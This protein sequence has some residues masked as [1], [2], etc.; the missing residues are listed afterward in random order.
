MQLM[1]TLVLKRGYQLACRVTSHLPPA[2]LAWALAK[3]LNKNLTAEIADG[4]FDFLNEKILQIA[5]LDFAIDLRLSKRGNEFTAVNTSRPADACIAANS[6]DLLAIITG[7]EDPD[8]LFFQRKLLISG[9]TELG[10]TAK[11]RLD[12]ID[13]SRLAPWL[14]TGIRFLDNT[15]QEAS[16][17]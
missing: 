5:V 3:G 12:A 17:A 1:K 7:R 15:L 13:K 8:A 4:D 2:P 10:L 9:D 11:N 16:V 6:T 14:Q